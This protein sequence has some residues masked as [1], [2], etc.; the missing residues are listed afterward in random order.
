MTD[1]TTTGP[2]P[3][4]EPAG[5]TLRP[6]HPAP[7]VSTHPSPFHARSVAPAGV[8]GRAVEPCPTCSGPIRETVAMVCQTCGTNYAQDTAILAAL[9]AAAP[10]ERTFEDQLLRGGLTSAEWH[11]TGGRGF[12]VSEGAVIEFMHRR[13]KFDYDQ[14][15]HGTYT[16][17]PSQGQPYAMCERQGRALVDF[18]AARPSPVVSGEAD[19]QARFSVCQDRLAE[20]RDAL[21]CTECGGSGSANADEGHRPPC[22][23]CGGSGDR[24]DEVRR[25]ARSVARDVVRRAMGVFLAA[26]GLTLADEGRA[27]MPEMFPGTHNAL[28]ALTIRPGEER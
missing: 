25:E 15:D 3:S 4:P 21:H 13:N 19:W 9:P 27:D 5:A 20:A 23:A 6:E 24:L 10:D 18:L 26:L 8:A 17:G 12:V 22:L 11:A 7:G 14:C 2:R 16:G 1:P 28:D